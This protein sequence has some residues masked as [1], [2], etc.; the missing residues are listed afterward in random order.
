MISLLRGTVAAIN[1]DNITLD[2][3]GVGY[4]VYIT[5]LERA[6]LQAEQPLT[7]Q[8]CTVVREDAI[9]LFGFGSAQQKDVFEILRSVNKVGP[10]LAMGILGSISVSELAGAVETNNSAILTK[11]PGIGKKT[12]QRMCLELKNKLSGVAVQLPVTGATTQKK[13]SDPLQLALAQLDYR[14]SEIDT[15]LGSGQVPDMDSA[16]IEERLR[17]ALI[18]LAKQN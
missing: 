7:L 14:K 5:Q 16:S 15:V 9:T 11:I 10:K 3:N 17:A 4:L 12:A 13:K 1:H 8:I 2:V 18:F 6:E